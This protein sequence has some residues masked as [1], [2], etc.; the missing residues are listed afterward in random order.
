[1]TKKVLVW[2]LPLRLFHWLLV[3]T[4]I[5]AWYT[6]DQDNDLIDYHLIFGYV[7][8]GLIIFRISWGFLGTTH[9][10]FSQFVPTLSKVIHYIKNFKQP[11]PTPYTGHNP[12]GGLMV[13]FMLFIILLQAISGLF[14]NDDIFTNGPYYGTINEEF[15]AVLIFFHRNSFNVILTAIALHLLAILFYKVVKKKPLVAAMITGKKSEE[16]VAQKDG[17]K[18]SKLVVA[19]II[20]LVVIAFVYWLVIINAPVMEEYY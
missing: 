8:L 9:A 20:T 17:I 14:M 3:A 16:E 10:K 19:F 4:I 11:Q 1:M 2:D 6:S 13:I 18:H 12:L 5:G 15:E 7:A